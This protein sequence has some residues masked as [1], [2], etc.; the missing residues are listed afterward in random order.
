MQT[1]PPP[2]KYLIFFFILYR[3]GVG[4]YNGKNNYIYRILLV[5]LL[6]TFVFKKVKIKKLKIKFYN[7][8]V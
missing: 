6:K 1:N 2:I 8:Q 4:N 5:I 7:F 3:G